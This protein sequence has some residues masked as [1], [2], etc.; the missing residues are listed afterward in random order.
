LNH[1]ITHSQP[2][3]ITMK[4]TEVTQNDV[5]K[6]TQSQSIWTNAEVVITNKASGGIK[7]IIFLASLAGIGLFFNGCT[8]GYVATEPSYVEYSRPERPSEYHIWI[9]GDWVFNN[10]THAYV[11]RNGYWERPI[12]GRT[13]V[14][15]QWQSTPKGKYWSKGRWQK[16]A[17]EGNR[18]NRDSR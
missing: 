5:P 16:K 1:V 11:Q 8:A 12:Q 3:K 13:Y 7:R 2:K 18:R 14:S 4:N 6:A 10:Q 17:R 15:G 9:D